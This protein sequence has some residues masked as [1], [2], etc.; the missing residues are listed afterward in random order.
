MTPCPTHGPDAMV[1]VKHPQYPHWRCKVCARER[2]HL[3]RVRR[4]ATFRGCG[5]HFRGGAEAASGGCG[6][7]FRA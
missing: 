6:S 4:V 1:L 7:S 2:D 5:N 3:R